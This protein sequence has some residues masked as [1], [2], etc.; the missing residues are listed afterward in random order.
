MILSIVTGTVD[1]HAS[2]QTFVDSVRLNTTVDYELLIVDASRDPINLI[3]PPSQ[4][5]VIREWPRQTYVAGYN[6]AFAQCRGKYVVWMNDDAEVTPGWD[7]SAV[8]F[9]DAHPEVGLGCLP[10]RDPGE[11]TFTVR[12][13][14]NLPYAN[15][16]I[17]RREIGEAVGWFDSD[18]TMYGSDN[19]ISCKVLIAGHGVAPI[20]DSKIEHHRFKDTV[21][22][23]N[24]HP[25]VVDGRT[26][27]RR[28]ST[29]V[30]RMSRAFWK[31]LPETEDCGYI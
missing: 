1:R 17:I 30:R 31:N 27:I 18:L 10:F 5:R 13:L 7:V 16:G 8:N 6:K 15:F 23:R 3:G 14:W 29:Q 2:I 22:F 21:R 11:S 12:E 26:I 24:Q 20:K 4:A 28:Y 9:M 25:R 19:S